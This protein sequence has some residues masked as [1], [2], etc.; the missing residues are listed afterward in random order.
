[1]AKVIYISGGQ[2]SGKS[3][4]AQ[5]KA[6][7]LSEKPYYLATARIWDDDFKKRVMR[8]KQERDA[9]W[10]NVEEEKEIAKV[11][12]P[13]KA[14]VVMDCVTLWLT[15]YYIDYQNNGH[16]SLEMAKKE[17]NAFVQKD[18][19]IIVVSNEIGMGLHAESAVGRAFVDIQGWMNQFIAKQADEC[20]FMASGIPLKTK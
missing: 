1:M 7:E 9:N 6:L 15:N 16:E 3:N 4:F 11:E 19:T 13:E 20:Y 8:H 5:Q 10:E 14:V 2:R 17:W 18:I 12:F